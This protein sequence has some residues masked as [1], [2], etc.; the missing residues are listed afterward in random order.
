MTSTVKAATALALAFSLGGCYYPTV[1]RIKPEPPMK[2]KAADILALKY[3]P[4]QTDLPKSRVVKLSNGVKVH[5]MRNDELPIVQVTAMIKAG[6]LWEPANK[7][8]LSA[9]TGIAIR[10]GGAGALGPDALNDTLEQMGAHVEVS[11]SEESARAFLSVLKKDADAGLSIFADVIKNPRFDPDRFELER[12]RAMDAVRR[13]NDEP[14]HIGDR[15]L[16]KLIYNG[17]PYGRS[18]TLETLR[19]ITVKDAQAFHKKYFTPSSMILGVTGDFDEQ[20]LLARLEGLFGKWK[21]PKPDYP[22]TAP[23]KEVYE[24]GLFV[25]AKKLPQAVIRAGHLTLKR[26][27]PDYH[28]VLVMDEILGGSGFASRLTQK[29][30][31]ER[32]LAYS[33][34]SYVNA[35]RWE[36]GIFA[37][38]AETKTASAGEVAGIFNEEI[39]KI[40]SE[41]VTP[42]ELALA[43]NSIVNSFVFIFDTPARIL[44][45]R[46]IVDYY[47]MP[48]GYLETFRDRVMAV[49]AGDV[50]RVARKYLHPEGLKMV[51]VGDPDV[52]AKSLPGY[53][54][55][56]KIALRDYNSKN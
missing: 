9:I 22:Q 47:G 16:R 37:V 42:E 12:A 54:S 13:E 3:K 8:G 45:Q 20:K 21:A 18:A 33:V 32:G 26:T 36:L 2:P 28:A 24:G 6:G 41:A 29:V 10:S 44:E 56:R 38:G 40:R 7:T 34:W 48:E 19:S 53:S 46:M 30:R 49:T 23:A 51:V 43:R 14:T 4:I 52:L 17:T 11:I 27:D 50:L 31:S 35:G 15:E 55:A 25:A 1:G 5:L 39:E